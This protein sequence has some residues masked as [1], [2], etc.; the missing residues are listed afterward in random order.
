[1]ALAL[2]GRDRLFRYGFA[3]LRLCHSF[4]KAVYQFPS[5][6]S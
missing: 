4:Q 1:M 2:E 3:F 6:S 5:S